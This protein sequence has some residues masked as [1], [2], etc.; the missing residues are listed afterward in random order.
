MRGDAGESED[1]V[2]GLRMTMP[3]P[4]GPDGGA[5]WHLPVCCFRKRDAQSY[6]S[7]LTYVRVSPEEVVERSTKSAGRSWKVKTEGKKAR[8]GPQNHVG[9]VPDYIPCRAKWINFKR[10]FLQ[11][12]L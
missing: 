8:S 1:R 9:L 3:N 10:T 11:L 5:S 6:Q 4:D 7:R 12:N 2:C